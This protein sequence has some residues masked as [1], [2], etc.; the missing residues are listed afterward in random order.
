LFFFPTQNLNKKNKKNTATD[1][2]TGGGR[3]PPGPPVD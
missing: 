3:R 2:I 1:N